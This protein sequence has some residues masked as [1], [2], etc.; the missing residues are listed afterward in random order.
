M[1]EILTQDQIDGLLSSGLGDGA[2][3]PLDDSSLAPAAGG[4]TTVVLQKAFETLN[5]QSA[6]VIT[7]LLNRACTLEVQECGKADKSA[8]AARLTGSLLALEV[9]FTAEVSGKIFFIFDKKEVAVLADLMMMGEGTADYT[10]D[11]KDAIGEL[12]NQ[13]MGGFAT[14]LS[15]KVALKASS[16]TIVVHE[17]NL[18]SPPFALDGCTMALSKI[19]INGMSDAAVA[20]FFDE[21]ITTVFAKKFAVL[22]DENAAAASGDDRGNT[23]LNAAELSDLASVTAS[24]SNGDMDGSSSFMETSFGGGR[25]SGTNAPR[26]NVNMLLDIPLDVSIELGRTT[27]SIKRVLELAPGAI[28]ELDRM[29]GEPVDLMVNDKVVA[30][31]EVVVVDENF[32]IRIVSL[33]SPEERIRSLR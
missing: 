30:K 12:C 21:S 32:G 1:S 8:V 7:T 11:H 13:I 14:S 2:G 33:V 3:A 5:E 16:G 27:M 9:P 28:I 6:S 15:G 24:D 23:G 18:D 25:S 29:A 4:D 20:C 26:E 19:T 31:G 10:E 22:V 17:C